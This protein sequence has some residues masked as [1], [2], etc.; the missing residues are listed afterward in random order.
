MYSTSGL[1][2]DV[3]AVPVIALGGMT[4]LG[5]P[6]ALRVAS[7]T[8]VICCR[9]LGATGRPMYLEFGSEVELIMR[10]ST[11]TAAIITTTIEMVI[12]RR[13]LFFA[14]SVARL[15]NLKA[16]DRLSTGR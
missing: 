16:T 10:A 13:F 14:L 6:N 7:L 5:T 4:P 9:T 3:S 15:P 12:I 1:P 2:P 11:T 8:P